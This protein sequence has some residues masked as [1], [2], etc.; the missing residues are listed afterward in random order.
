M[1]YAKLFVGFLTAGIAFIL[2]NF[3]LRTIRFGA[4]S[5]PA[6]SNLPSDITL[7]LTRCYINQTAILMFWVGVAL[8]IVAFIIGLYGYFSSRKNV[9]AKLEPQ[10]AQVDS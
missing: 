1:K 10:P 6:Y 5:C 8:V 2:T 3:Y 9:P 7:W 4:G